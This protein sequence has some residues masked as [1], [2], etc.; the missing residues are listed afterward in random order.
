MYLVI[1]VKKLSTIFDRIVDGMAV[2]AFLVIVFVMFSVSVEVTARYVF[3]IPVSW[4]HETTE[5]SLLFMT[6]LAATWVLKGERHVRMEVVFNRFS[7]RT[8]FMLNTVTSIIMAIVFMIAIWYGTIATVIFY[9]TDRYTGIL[10][11]LP[12]WVIMLVVPICSFFLS[13]QLMR[14]A[15]SNFRSFM[16]SA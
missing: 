2:L 13:I 8:R 16:E 10:V 15:Y 14:R 4:V 1:L 11:E 6:M 7:L 12:L 5:Y 3:N 9:Q